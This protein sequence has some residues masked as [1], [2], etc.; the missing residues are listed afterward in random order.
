M[1]KMIIRGVFAPPPSIRKLGFGVAAFTCVP[2]GDGKMPRFPANS[3]P[4]ALPH[5]RKS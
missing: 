4:R 2:G 3:P 1:H 5:G